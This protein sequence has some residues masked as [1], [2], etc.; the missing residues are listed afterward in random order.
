MIVVAYVVTAAALFWVGSVA[1]FLGGAIFVILA[2]ILAGLKLAGVIAWSWWWI[3]LSLWTAIG[4]AVAKMWIV[5]RD[6]LWLYKLQRK[7]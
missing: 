6:P 4:G 1:F 3:V 2:A 7:D 5:T